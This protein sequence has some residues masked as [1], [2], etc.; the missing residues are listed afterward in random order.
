MVPFEYLQEE[1]VLFL[2]FARLQF[3]L[4]LELKNNILRTVSMAWGL[5]LKNVSGIER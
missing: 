3:R 5:D 4:A 1:N 2:V